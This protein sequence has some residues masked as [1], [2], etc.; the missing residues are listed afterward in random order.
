MSFS[1][2]V[3]LLRLAMMAASRQG[4]CLADVEAEFACVRRT[5]QRMIEALQSAFPAVEHRI[6]DDRRHYWRLPARAIAQLLSP[7]AD[8][9]AAMSSAIVE[10][11]RA[12]MSSEADRLL[13]LNRKVRALIPAESG[14]RLAVDEEALLE[15]MGYAARPGPQPATSPEVDEAIS[16]AIKGPFRLTLEYQSRGDA[17]P[18]WRTIE[19]LGLLLGARRYLVGIDLA[20]RDGRY[21]HYRVEDISQA[22]VLDASFDYPED[23]DFRAY[24]S[25]A[26][27]SFHNDAEYGEVVWRFAPEA[28]GRARRFLFHP[29]QSSECC[30]DGSLLVRFKASGHVEMAWH[31]Y[32]WGST[33][34]VVEPAGLAAMVHPYRR[35]DFPAL[36]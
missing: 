10:L 14:A 25:R 29:S 17:E 22:E 15:A 33:V 26:F 18:S 28:A 32:A 11:K 16:Q 2:G 9:L 31:L 24:A 19:P 1:K 7:S 23:F 30:E 12:G 35:A 34:E 6:D 4:I 8:E 21:R 3:D 36:P 5:A 27:G 13:G 20:K